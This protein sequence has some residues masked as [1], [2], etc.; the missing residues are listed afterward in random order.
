MLEKRKHFFMH[1][2]QLPCLDCVLVLMFMLFI[3]D[4]FSSFY[5]LSRLMLLLCIFLSP[6]S[7]KKTLKFP[8]KE[9]YLFSCCCAYVLVIA[10]I[11]IEQKR[12]FTK[13]NLKKVIITN[14][15]TLSVNFKSVLSCLSIGLEWILLALLIAH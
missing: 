12:E 10:V 14:Y 7:F 2:F 6:L 4:S 8:A 11:S 3:H 5:S 15:F 9:K 1:P 13:I